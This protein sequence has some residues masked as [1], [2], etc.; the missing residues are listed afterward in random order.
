MK[1][2]KN[3]EEYTVLKRNMT[4]VNTP[5]NAPWTGS[6]LSMKPLTG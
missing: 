3:K 6:K 5:L 2:S 4:Q 1:F